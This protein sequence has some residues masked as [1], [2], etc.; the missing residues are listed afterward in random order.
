MAAINGNVTIENIDNASLLLL[1][2]GQANSQR[3]IDTSNNRLQITAGGEAK[4][5]ETNIDAESVYFDGTGDTLT[6]AASSSLDLTGDFTIEF[7]VNA[8][9]TSYIVCNGTQTG[10]GCWYFYFNAATGV[11]TYAMAITTW[12]GLVLTTPNSS[13]STNTWTHITVTRSGNSFRLFVNGVVA[14][15]ATNA[16]S[17][18]NTGRVLQIGYYVESTGTYYLTGYLWNLRII[19]G[20]ALYTSNFIPS[21]A[22]LTA[23]TNTV[24]LTCQGSTIIDRST[25]NFTI[26][27]AGNVS[28]VRKAPSTTKLKAMYFDGAVDNLSIASTALLSFGTG[29]FTWECWFYTETRNILWFSTTNDAFSVSHRVDGR[30]YV[31]GSNIADY[32]S[33]PAP[34]SNQW[35]HVA[36]TR[37]GTS[38]RMFINGKLESTVTNSTNFPAGTYYIGNDHNNTGA[39]KGYIAGLRVIKGNAL[40]T[41]NFVPKLVNQTDSFSTKYKTD[42]SLPNV[43]LLVKS[44]S[45]TSST[46]FIDS[47]INNLTVTNNSTVT[48]SSVQKIFGNSSI[49]FNGS[50]FL[51]IAAN[52]RFLLGTNNFTIECWFYVTTLATQQSLIASHQTGGM[53]GFGVYTSGR[54]YISVNNSGGAGTAY[55]DLGA[56]QLLV[57][58][59]TWYHLAAVRDGATIR[60]F[61]NGVP[62]ATTLNIGTTNVGSYGGNK[63]IYIGA[64]ADTTSKVTGYIDNV[65]YTVGIARY[66]EKFLVPT[67]DFPGVR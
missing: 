54:P 22:S 8:Q 9:A 2:E 63:P 47:S 4:I 19:K 34:N 30:V 1:P 45:A 56:T 51:S 28:I 17:L 20:T 53:F 39:Y 23:I 16:G 50:N 6:V 33:A 36:I 55:S 46:T 12:A 66:K 27:P 11:L 61:L 31:R 18:I 38:L 42:E 26:T 41:T 44:S 58:I 35:Y 60:L 5:V 24:L 29:D 48:Q 52:S 21:I 3:F 64:G 59:N 15:T 14:A 13:M 10:S 62:D 37:Q 43:E 67:R 40:Y 7:W 32:I 49:N 65:R 25:N 57:S